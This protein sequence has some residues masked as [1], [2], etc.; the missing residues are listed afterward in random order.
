MII[1]S[2]AH[3]AGATA[4]VFFAVRPAGEPDAE[5]PHDRFDEQGEETER[6]LEASVTALLLDSTY[7]Q[8]LRLNL[9]SYTSFLP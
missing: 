4:A 8:L 2:R 5:K 1:L 7:S 9:Q 3:A 6:C